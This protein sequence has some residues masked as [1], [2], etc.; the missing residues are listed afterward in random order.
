[1]ALQNTVPS[2][3]KQHCHTFMLKIGNMNFEAPGLSN[4]RYVQEWFT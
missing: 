4:F 2:A 1:M 3:A